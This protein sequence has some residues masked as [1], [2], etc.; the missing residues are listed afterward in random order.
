MSVLK[1]LNSLQIWLL[2]VCVAVI[3]MVGVGGATRLTHSGLSMV[4]W[5]PITG[6][7]PPLSAQA[8]DA[9]FDQYKQYP[10]YQK[11]NKGMS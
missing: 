11:L 10:E 6:I 8:W 4:D 9:A 2:L 5:K 3:L 1:G 7:I